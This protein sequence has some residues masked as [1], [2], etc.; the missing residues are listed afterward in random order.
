MDRLIQCTAASRRA[1]QA[2]DLVSLDGEL[3]VV[4][5]LLSFSN[6]SFG[7]NDNL[8]LAIHRDDLGVTVG[9]TLRR[10]SMK[11]RIRKK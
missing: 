3:V 7:V 2:R 10:H 1:A 9:L 8:L 5:D 4:C 11:R 6:V